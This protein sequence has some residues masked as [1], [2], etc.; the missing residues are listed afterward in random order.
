M[1]NLDLNDLAVRHDGCGDVVQQVVDRDARAVRDGLQHVPAGD[2]HRLR[3]ERAV[4]VVG[5]GVLPE[6]VP[7][8]GLRRVDVR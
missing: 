6:V 3:G 7:D 1:V 4:R 8:R 2:Q 5:G